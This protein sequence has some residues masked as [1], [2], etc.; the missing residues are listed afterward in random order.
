MEDVQVVVTYQ[1]SSEE[2]SGL[3]VLGGGGRRGGGGGACWGGVLGPLSSQ[4]TMD[5]FYIRANKLK[6]V[7]ALALRAGKPLTKLSLELV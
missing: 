4:G 3:G 1:H 6:Q 2:Q 5:Y 7:L